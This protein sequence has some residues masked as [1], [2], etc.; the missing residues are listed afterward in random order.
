[1][2]EHEGNTTPA[3]TQ[4]KVSEKIKK[5]TVLPLT[6]CK[7]IMA[8]VL[9]DDC[10][11]LFWLTAAAAEGVAVETEALQAGKKLFEAKL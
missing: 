7:S 5:K 10:A 9:K 6:L 2:S 8:F 3:E 4:E 11:L 1:M